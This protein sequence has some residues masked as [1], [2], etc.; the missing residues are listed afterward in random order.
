MNVAAMRSVLRP[1]EPALADPAASAGA[2]AVQGEPAS[3]P[4]AASSN[5]ETAARSA[6]ST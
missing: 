2:A 1:V 3:G 6:G 4:S 5:L